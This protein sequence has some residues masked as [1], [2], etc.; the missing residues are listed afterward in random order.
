MIQV[1][2][3]THGFGLVCPNI[4][5]TPSPPSS[6]TSSPVNS[7]ADEPAGEV[8]PQS[9][10]S[11]S[12]EVAEVENPFLC[13]KAELARIQELFDPRW[14]VGS[15]VNFAS[16]ETCLLQ[17]P[18]GTF[19]IVHGAAAKKFY[20]IRCVYVPL[21]KGWS[22]APRYSSLELTSEGRLLFEE[23]EYESLAEL[24]QSSS[25]HSGFIE[26]EKS[27]LNRYRIAGFY[28]CR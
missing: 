16:L 12:E 6:E 3:L 25:L 14:F 28:V 22:I 15:P 21:Q 11:V 17:Y 27:H 26:T 24:C 18:V 23:A 7:G 1:P 19:A 2:V 9:P 13:N 8:E 20:L 10:L 4:T 5:W